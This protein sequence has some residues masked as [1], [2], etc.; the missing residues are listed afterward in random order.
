MSSTDAR[1]KIYLVLRLAC[2]RDQLDIIPDYNAS[3]AR[4]YRDIAVLILK[5]YPTLDILSSAHAN[6]SLELPS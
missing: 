1:D 4:V 3:P 5:T 2:D 6:K